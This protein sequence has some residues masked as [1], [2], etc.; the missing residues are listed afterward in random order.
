GG[1]EFQDGWKAGSPIYQKFLNHLL[2]VPCHLIVT[3]RSKDAYEMV[4]YVK[5]DGNIGKCPK[6]VGSAPVI[7]KYF[8]YEMQFMI[9]VDEMVGQIMSSAYQEELPKGMEIESMSADFAP[10]L[11]RFLDGAPPPERIP[12]LLETGKRGLVTGAWTKETFYATASKALRV[13]VSR[14]VALS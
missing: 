12:T 7:R 5:K 9:R 2:N 4:D 6:N 11:L 13:A 10:A 3:L 8:G 1:N 14:D